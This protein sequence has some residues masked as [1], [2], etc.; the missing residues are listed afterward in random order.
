MKFEDGDRIWNGSKTVVQFRW[1]EAR[2]ASDIPICCHAQQCISAHI[3]L[4]KT[5]SCLIPHASIYGAALGYQEFQLLA[6][7]KLNARPP[8]NSNSNSHP[9]TIPE[10]SRV[11]NRRHNTSLQWESLK[12]NYLISSLGPALAEHKDSY[13]SWN[14]K[15]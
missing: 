6:T 13:T 3:F 2:W 7:P 11:M 4:I 10:V 15:P 9:K 5:G 12:R 14:S 1:R 8:H